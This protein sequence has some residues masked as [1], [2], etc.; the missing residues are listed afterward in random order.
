[1]RRQP[2]G[3]PYE[4]RF[5][6]AIDRAPLVDGNGA[7]VTLA[8]AAAVGGKS[9]SDGVQGADRALGLVVGVLQ[10]PVGQLVYRIQGLRGRGE[11]G[12]ILHEP[13]GVLLLA[14]AGCRKGVVLAVELVKHGAEGLA[15]GG[16]RIV[17]G[18]QDIARFG[19]GGDVADPPQIA[20]VAPAVQ[21]LG[22]RQDRLFAHAVDQHMGPGVEQDRSPDPVRPDVVMGNPAQAGLQPTQDDGDISAAVAP[23]QVGIGD[24]SPVRSAVVDPPGGVVVFLALLPQRG[25]VGHQGV[26]AAACDPPEKPR[27][28]QA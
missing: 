2:A 1:M 17:G 4:R 26:H 5:A 27:P 12:R 24:D 20:I 3:F 28:A 13:A 22:Q 14:E 23:N 8:I 10:M 21:G 25:V 16:H 18:E 19:L 15:V 11:G 7:E 6:A 9:E